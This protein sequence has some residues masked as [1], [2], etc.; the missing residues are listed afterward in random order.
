VEAVE[1]PLEKIGGVYTLAVRINK[2][3]TL[4]FILDSG[5]SEVLIPAEVA[6][7][8]Q[9]S[10]TIHSADHL[11]ERVYVLADGS[12]MKKHRFRL[13]SLEIGRSEIKNVPAAVGPAGS[14]P[15]L[16]QSVL[17]KLG[18]WSLD[19]SRKVLIIEDPVK[20]EPKPKPRPKTKSS[21][22]FLE[23]DDHGLLT[24]DWPSLKKQAA[25]YMKSE[26]YSKA[27]TYLEK[28]LKI[29]E[30][31]LGIK[32]YRISETASMLIRVYEKQG[33]QK[34]ADSLNEWAAS[35]WGGN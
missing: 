20:P 14:P 24:E 13:R 5:A 3:I 4:N 7:T 32:D 18:V 6:L 12:K 28:V 16:G 23:E 27:Q 17:E 10:G 34:E 35:V 2:V 11:P 30:Q 15:L 9:R 22:I 31:T 26:E 21:P 1:I 29:Q 19:S 8:L 33:K 25:L